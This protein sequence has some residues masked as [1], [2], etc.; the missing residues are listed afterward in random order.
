MGEG[1]T[2]GQRE[3]SVAYIALSSKIEGGRRKARFHCLHPP[4]HNLAHRGTGKKNL[5]KNPVV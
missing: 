3:I 4:T 5:M 2:H 1:K